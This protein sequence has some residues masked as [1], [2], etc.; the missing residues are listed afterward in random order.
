MMV[1]RAGR[2]PAVVPAVFLDGSAV[3]EVRQF[4]YLGHILTDDLSDDLDMERERRATSVRSNMLAR[5]FGGCSDAV[6][7]TLFKAFCQCLYTCQLWVKHKRTSHSLMRVQYNDSFRI[8]MRLP[9]YCS[10][11]GMF[12]DARVPDYFAV[13]RARIASFW[14]RLRCSKNT[15]LRAVCEDMSNPIYRYWLSAHRD[16]NRKWDRFG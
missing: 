1:F 12:A 6:R 3:R 11:S 9:R 10:A 13:V 8:L 4:K 16:P 5:R 7:I 15:V 14:K 2:G